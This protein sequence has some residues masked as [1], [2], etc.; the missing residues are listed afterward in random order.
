[1]PYF[2]IWPAVVILFTKGIFF[3]CRQRRGFVPGVSMSP[4]RGA[5]IT[6]HDPGLVALKQILRG[7]FSTFFMRIW[8]RAE[9]GKVI[10]PEADL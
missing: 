3:R 7:C 5:L 4:P 8:S 1:M 2:V 6:E 9:V 10:L